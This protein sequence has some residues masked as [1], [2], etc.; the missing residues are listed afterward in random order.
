MWAPPPTSDFFRGWTLPVKGAGHIGRLFPD[1]QGWPLWFMTSIA[2]RGLH[3]PCTGGCSWCLIALWG[4]LTWVW[5]GAPGDWRWFGQLDMWEPGL[6]GYWGRLLTG[7]WGDGTRA[8]ASATWL[9]GV[10]VWGI[11]IPRFL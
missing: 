4:S 8:P 5:E 6:G 2:L 9:G 1:F 7:C 11:G 10:G 3:R